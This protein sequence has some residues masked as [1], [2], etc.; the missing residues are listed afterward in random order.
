MGA[1]AQVEARVWCD[2]LVLCVVCETWRRAWAYALPCAVLSC[3]QVGMLRWCVLRGCDCP[4]MFVPSKTC[5]HQ[6]CDCPGLVTV[7]LVG[8]VVYKGATAQNLWCCRVRLPR[9]CGLAGCDCQDF[10]EL[11]APLWVRPSECVLWCC[12]ARLPRTCGVTVSHV[13]TAFLCGRPELVLRAI[14]GCAC[15]YACLLWCCGARLPKT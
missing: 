1:T 4:D 8:V 7:G 11:T 13:S 10:P 9:T 3:C 5:S 6:G 12:R 15:P 2:C 14:P